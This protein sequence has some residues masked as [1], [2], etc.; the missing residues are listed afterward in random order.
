MS[1]RTTLSV[2][3]AS[4]LLIVLGSVSLHAGSIGL[5]L[6]ATIPQWTLAYENQQS[7]N[8]KNLNDFAICGITEFELTKY[9]HLQIE[10][11]Y[12]R[13]E[14]SVDYQKAA[15]QQLTTM[16]FPSS[17]P[18]TLSF[19]Q[20]FVNINCPVLL[21]ISPFSEGLRPYLLTGLVASI[22][23]SATSTA[24]FDTTNL[25]LSSPIDVKPEAKAVGYAFQLGA[26]IQIPLL[27]SLSIVGDAR[28]TFA[29][30]DAASLSAFNQSLGTVKASNLLIMVGAC[31]DW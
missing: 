18:S 21:K 9:V 11:A 6:G 10:P 26:G 31:I 29:L 13:E 7:Q 19:T 25:N 27:G 16:P 24:S 23:L 15:L 30:S 12:S 3:S 22:N 2:V 17:L 20:D 4:L 14:F 5:K 1:H 28:Y 8:L